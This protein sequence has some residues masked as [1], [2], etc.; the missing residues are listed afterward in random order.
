MSYQLR[1][2]PE[3]VELIPARAATACVIWMHGLGASGHDFVPIVPHLGLPRNSTVR[4]VFP[5]APVRA[6]TL[7]QGF[8]MRAWYDIRELSAGS[9]EDE[10]GILESAAL[11][12][13]L[14]GR[15]AAAGVPMDRVV[16]AGFSQ[17]GAMALHVGTR[18]AGSLAGILAL[19]TYLPMR[20]RLPTEGNPGNRSVPILMCHGQRDPVLTIQ[21]GRLSR[22]ALLAQGYAVQWRE[23]EMAHEVCDQ[24]ILD[25]GRWLRDRLP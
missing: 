25:I 21:I 20:N 22:D 12:E 13:A 2:S 10:A 9:S 19:S 15:E 16:L 6:V 18:S 5:H 1:E 24:E 4:F 14:I 7:N 11:I 3:G 8:R 23:Y 17:G